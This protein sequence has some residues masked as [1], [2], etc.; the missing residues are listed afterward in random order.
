[1]AK[2]LKFTFV[3]L[4]SSLLFSSTF[5]GCTKK[6]SNEEVGKLEEA[7][8]AAESAERKLSE[9]RVERMQLEK[10]LDGTKGEE[11]GEKQELEEV[12]SPE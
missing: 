7:K 11:Q 2:F 12:Q 6:P 9:L 1:M 8:A 3:A 10:D 5:V 4:L